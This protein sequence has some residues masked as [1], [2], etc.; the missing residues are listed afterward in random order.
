MRESEGFGA[1][2]TPVPGT[3]RVFPSPRNILLLFFWMFSVAFAASAAPGGGR[4]AEFSSFLALIGLRAGIF[5]TSSVIPGGTGGVWGRFLLRSAGGSGR[6][7]IPRGISASKAGHASPGVR[8]PRNSPK[9]SG[10]G[11]DSPAHSN[12]RGIPGFIL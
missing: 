2:L 1:L 8:H 9:K 12:L 5:G 4:S 7:R 10:F 3:S 11:G 6:S